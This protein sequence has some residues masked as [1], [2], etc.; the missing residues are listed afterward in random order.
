M[1]LNEIIL[2]GSALAVILGSFLLILQFLLT[3]FSKTMA[4]IEVAQHATTSALLELVQKAR[5]GEAKLDKIHK[6]LERK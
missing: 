1:D 4:E 2:Q 3:S 6:L 5:S